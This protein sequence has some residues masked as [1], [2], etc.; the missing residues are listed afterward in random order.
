MR[1]LHV[2]DI[3][4]PMLAGYT[5][6]SKY[7]VN[8]QRSL[9]LDPVVVTS[10]RHESEAD[11]LQEIFDDSRYYRTPNGPPGILD[12]ALN[13]KPLV[14]E[15]REIHRLRKR[16]VEVASREQPDIIHA[17]S[18]ILCGIPAYLASRQLGIPCV[19]EIRAFW[20]DAAVDRGTNAEG[21]AKYRAI[22]VAETRLAQQ[23]DAVIGICEGIKGELIHRGIDET[24]I[25]VIPNGVVTERF[26]PMPPDPEVMAQY[27]FDGKTVV[28]YIGTFAKFEGVPY[29]VKALI[30]LMKSGRDDLRGIIVGSGRTY[31]DC[32]K[33]AEEAGLADKIVH[34]GRVSH[35][36]VRPLYSV[37]DIFAYPRESARITELVTPLKPLEAMSMKKSVIGSD[38]GGL[39]EL[40]QDEETGL[41]HKHVDVDDLASKIIRLVD[42]PE[43]R[44][45]FGESGRA[46]VETN[47][48]WRHI[49]EG[50][51]KV[52]ERAR[53]N[54]SK[55]QYLWKGL[56]AIS[57]RLS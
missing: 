46:Y 37:V 32:R 44:K 3:S 26:E 21:S 36:E 35:D 57:D 18:S 10:P 38:V 28:G 33:L 25:F 50:H 12:D 41:I 39:K 30:Q 7:I 5:L 29:L 23:V 31:E 34:P 13:D 8:T 55:N 17:H 49:I 19:Y 53:A 15:S 43:L 4:I 47:R 27:K 42:N 22:Q 2:L 20:E 52:Y 9:G 54:W 48:E 1:V 56:A 16:I 45:Q 51:F 6:R 14:T 11:V 40:I 24:N